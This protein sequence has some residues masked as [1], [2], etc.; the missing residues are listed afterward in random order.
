MALRNLCAVFCGQRL[1]V[2]LHAAILLISGGVV[3]ANAQTPPPPVLISQPTST[4]AIAL[5]SLN[6]VSEPFKLESPYSYGPDRRTR[7]LLF[8]VN[9]SLQPG[10]TLSSVSADAEDASHRHYSLVVEY[11][12]PV[13]G[14]E[15]L[16]AVV[17]RLS[18]DL[19]DVG[20]VLVR[21]THAGIASN[22]VRVAIGH[23][24]GGPPDDPGSAPTPAPPYLITGQVTSAG[25][26]LSGV[27]VKLNGPQTET[28]IS[29]A[30]GGYQFMVQTA[31]GTYSI[32]A[33]KAFYDFSAGPTFPNLSNNQSNV[34]FTAQR[35][36]HTISGRVLDDAGQGIDAIQVTI[37]NEA[38]AI[39]GTML[40]SGGGSYSFPN[41]PAGFGYTITPATNSFFSFTPRST[42]LLSGNLIFD[43]NGIRRSHAIG[44]IITNAAG[45]GISGITINLSGS[46]SAA[47]I[48]DVSGAFSFSGLPAGGNYTLTPTTTAYYTFT[49]Q[50]INNLSSNQT[51][52]FTGTLR[53]YS[54]SGRVMNGT[55]GLGA[56]TIQ[57]TGSQS[58]GAVTDGSGNF[59]FADLPAG[60]NYTLTPTT[61]AFY[62]FTA[63]T[64][65]NLGN[66]QV[67]NFN[68]T[69]RKYSIGGRVTG[70]T[71]GIG[72]LDIQL[73]GSQSGSTVTD[74]SGNF[75]F[76]DLPA[77]GN[78]TLTPVA[79]SFYAFT[80]Q[81]I[82]E[83]SSNQTANFNGA[84][85][86]YSI[87]GRMTVGTQG[88][89][90][91]EIYL[92]GSRS[93]VTVTGSNGNFLF[94]DL[95]AAG[96]YTLTPVPTPFYEF[97]A[98]NVNNLG[99]NQALTFTGV[100]RKYSFNGRIT[101]GVSGLSGVNIAL[102][103][104]E[105]AVTTTDS[106]GN[107]T[108]AKVTAG[109]TY[110]LTPTKSQYVFTPPALLFVGV[111]GDKTADFR[112]SF[113]YY[114]A[115]RVADNSGRSLAGIT[116]TVS[117]DESATTLTAADGSY[118]FALAPAGNYTVTPS[119]EQGWYSFGPTSQSFNNLTSNQTTNFTG[120]QDPLPNPPYV[121]EFDGS[122][123]AVD[124]GY[125]W[126]PDV[127]LGHFFWEFWAMPGNNAGATYL[128]SDGYGGAH[129]LLFGFANFGST[130][131]GR[132]QF[133]G[134][135]YNGITHDNSFR[136]DEGPA[137][138]EWGHFAVG[139]DGRNIITYLNGVPVGKIPFTGPRRTPGIGGG[140]GR[141]LIGGSDHNNL[142]GR[143]AQ[144]RGYEGSNPREDPNGID[145]SLV[146][147]A[148]DPQNVFGAGGNLVSYYFRS[149]PQ[150]ADLS[151]GLNGVT[152]PGVVRGTINGVLAGC[153]GCP[154]PTFVIDPTAPNFATGT[155][156][157]P[158]AVANP[159]AVPAGARIFDSFSRANSTYISGGKGGLGATEGGAAG[160]KLWQTSV[161]SEKQPYGI[162]N[163][164]AVMLGNSTYISWIPTGSSSATLDIRVDR[165]PGGAGSGDDTGLCFRVVG[166]GNFFFA[167]S[168]PGSN[169]SGPRSLT[170]GYYL[171]GQRV[172]LAT[173]VTLPNIWTTL[174]VVTRSSGE[175]T[176][177]A[178]GIQVYTTSSNILPT[179]TGAGLYNNSAG[180]GLVNRWDNFTVYDA[181]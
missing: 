110:T 28:F 166:G 97:S 90:D 124:Y 118:S 36:R 19:G 87:A 139:W 146:E 120:A 49:A 141:L 78:Y 40:T 21:V 142:D 148:F 115:G 105:Q 169:P 88:I 38:D 163:G 136:S 154:L 160:T 8:A 68:G 81:T 61:N 181:P 149:A 77:G 71:N 74:G 147:S 122:P 140:G 48:S 123:K 53:K 35:Q 133:Y 57:L 144:V 47:V 85:R 121:L 126:E 55:D 51:A 94:S 99:S 113:R 91:V 155:P 12:G 72:S 4:R 178:G 7:V 109:G 66:N 159:A 172:I 63:Q 27:T 42:S 56:V 102:T 173:G 170:V 138:G 117:G 15:W 22:R 30:T 17:L 100:L 3:T 93:A 157:A 34:N 37:R 116:M 151:G 79:T 162:L 70:G 29:D 2:G 177:Y 112:S 171:N 43:F 80:P 95:P 167:Y 20:D 131:P 119:I 45:S 96:N 125:I 150:V 86:K 23:I 108:F 143:I 16:T 89:G 46:R 65:N 24:G 82:N 175:L 137:P 62:T 107:F 176:V 158:V 14:Q 106:N 180:Q 168:S 101:E 174:Q 64:I 33:T 161:L 103:G 164:R 58:G 98:Q 1:R 9:L 114:V 73:S 54:I 84:L 5:E 104:T 18:D 26:G 67:A 39:I 83:L 165:H 50:S 127:D 52:N 152:H 60:G 69:L 32:T 132:Y 128:L 130:E 75:L 13:P 156:A 76:A 134:N 31:G 92:T 145:Q 25:A 44:G 111:S 10:E 129:A 11:V 153:S 59:Q 41:V 6:F 135:I 179:A